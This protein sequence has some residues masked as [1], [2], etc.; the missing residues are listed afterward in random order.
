MHREAV[1]SGESSLKSKILCD[2]LLAAAVI[3]LA[4]ILFLALRF[5]S[6]DG[7][8]AVVY[9]DGDVLMRLPLDVDT[10]QVIEHGDYANTVTVKDGA[11]YVS[12]ANCPDGICRDHRPISKT[13][14]SIICLPNRLVITVEGTDSS[15]DVSS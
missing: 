13:N 12:Y 11:V 9:Y 1:R 2:V 15:V 5:L 10:E 4:L 6:S 3:I 14:E 7:G 8:V